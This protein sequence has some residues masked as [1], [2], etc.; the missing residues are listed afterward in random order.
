VARRDYNEAVR[1]Y[2]TTLRTFP[3]ALWAGT[4]YHNEKPMALFSATASAQSAPTVSFD[5][6]PGAAPGSPPPSPAT[7]P[8]KP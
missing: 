2:N 7:T 4:L 8:A 1:V 5:A 6:T 3:G